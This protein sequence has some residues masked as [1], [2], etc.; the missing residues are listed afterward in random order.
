MK[1]IFGLFLVAAIVFGCSNSAKQPSKQ[2][3]DIQATDMH[4]SRTSLNYY[5]MY[6]G[7]V[8]CADCEG[9]ETTIILGDTDYSIKTVYLGKNKTEYKET[10][11]YSWNENV[12]I[13]TLEG[14]KNAPNQ[15]FVGEN[16]L[17][18]LDMNGDEITGQWAE[19]YILRKD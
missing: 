4:T 13:I 19:M 7:T 17:K 2:S 5:G 3:G 16:Y 14:I 6:S 1:Q 11:V 10:G 18:Q 15:Y 12:Q 9:I 8:P